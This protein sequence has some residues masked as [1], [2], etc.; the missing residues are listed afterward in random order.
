MLDRDDFLFSRD[1]PFEQSA[2]K[3]AFLEFTTFT[4]FT[5]I[6]FLQAMTAFKQRSTH[7]SIPPRRPPKRIPSKN[8]RCLTATPTCQP[9]AR[10]RT[11]RRRARSGRS[12][13]RAGERE[14][15]LFQ[16]IVKICFQNHCALQFVR[17]EEQHGHNWSSSW[18]S[19]GVY[20]GNL[21][22]TSRL[23]I[24]LGAV[25]INLCTNAMIW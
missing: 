23:H 11:G 20:V 12:R 10:R 15:D 9:W 22:S 2:G 5:W 18:S 4:G 13:R 1:F 3:N 16:V 24:S 8:P 17:L 7:P 21:G 6:I 25:G 14:R 19:L